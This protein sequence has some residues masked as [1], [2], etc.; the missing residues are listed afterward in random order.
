MAGLEPGSIAQSLSQ[1]FLLSP[2]NHVATMRNIMH[3]HNAKVFFW[4]Y[5]SLAKCESCIDHFD[6]DGNVKKRMIHKTYFGYNM[7]VLI[8]GKSESRQSSSHQGKAVL[9]VSDEP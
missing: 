6:D 7:Q 1:A 4:L 9:T 8:G 2:L 3:K 5:D